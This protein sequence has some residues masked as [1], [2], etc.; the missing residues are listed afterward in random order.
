MFLIKILRKEIKKISKSFLELLTIN[1]VILLKYS[2][3]KHIGNDPSEMLFHCAQ[4]I[5]SDKNSVI[6]SL[7]K[8]KIKAN[9]VLDSQSFN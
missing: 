8:L 1:T 4:N 6:S 5:N 2:Y 7:G 9:S 3:E